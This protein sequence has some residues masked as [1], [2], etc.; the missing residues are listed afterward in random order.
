[1]LPAYGLKIGIVVLQLI[2][3]LVPSFEFSAEVFGWPDVRKSGSYGSVDQLEIQ[4]GIVG[5]VDCGHVEA[6]RASPV[7][8]RGW[9]RVRWLKRRGVIACLI[10]LGPSLGR[11]SRDVDCGGPRG[12]NFKEASRRIVGDVDADALADGECDGH[13]WCHKRMDIGH[14]ARQ[15][16]GGV[17]VVCPVVSRSLSSRPSICPPPVRSAPGSSC[18]PSCVILLPPAHFALGSDDVGGVPCSFVGG[19]TLARPLFAVASVA[20]PVSSVSS[21]S[22]GSSVSCDIL[23]PA[24][25]R[26]LPSHSVAVAC[27]SV[28][29]RPRKC[30]SVS[31]QGGCDIAVAPF[32]T[33]RDHSMSKARWWFP[34][35]T[36]SPHKVIL[37]RQ[38]I[39][40]DLGLAASCAIDVGRSVVGPQASGR[41]SQKLP[42]SMHHVLRLRGGGGDVDGDVSGA[43]SVDLIDEAVGS[44]VGDGRSSLGADSGDAVRV[45]SAGVLANEE[46][47]MS[48]G[49]GHAYPIFVE[50][51]RRPRVD[52]VFSPFNADPYPDVPEF[53]SRILS[54]HPTI[55]RDVSSASNARSSRAVGE[56]QKGN[57]VSQRHRMV[58][59]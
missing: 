52:F 13:G 29:F 36:Q 6:A 43:G 59:P 5:C 37:H 44:G 22:V 19:C 48:S 35:L 21:L 51:Y 49:V 2:I 12:W 34:A 39:V 56:N 53:R 11:A 31:V 55:P 4:M 38:V 16:S 8:P 26:R 28:R 57:A 42:C 32:G 1:M 7:S 41:Q 24:G 45:A 23:H 15:G 9:R 17:V 50:G 18:F 33:P 10:G 58:V 20:R 25:S 46:G 3:F 47:C 54:A 27:H 40:V 30:C 14:S